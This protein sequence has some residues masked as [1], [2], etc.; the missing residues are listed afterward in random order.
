MTSI[1]HGRI[2]ACAIHETLFRKKYYGAP[3]ARELF[4]KRKSRARSAS[5]LVLG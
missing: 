5:L 1:T 4:Q 3:C 2:R